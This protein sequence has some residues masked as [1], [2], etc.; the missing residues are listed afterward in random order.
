MMS[1]K[2]KKRNQLSDV[3]NQL[4]ACRQSPLIWTGMYHQKNI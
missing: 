3:S 4:L 2:K 1:Y